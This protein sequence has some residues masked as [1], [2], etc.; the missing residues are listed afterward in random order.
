[1]RLKT[2]LK[3]YYFFSDD[4][5]EDGKVFDADVGLHFLPS[6]WIRLSLLLRNVFKTDV[7]YYISRERV[8]S[9]FASSLPRVVNGNLS[10]SLPLDIRLVGGIE[11]LFPEPLNSAFDIAIR[12]R[13]SYRFSIEKELHTL[14]SLKTIYFREAVPF[15]R[16]AQTFSHYYIGGSSNWRSFRLGILAGIN[17][18]DSKNALQRSNVRYSETNVIRFSVL[19]EYH[20]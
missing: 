11:N 4:I 2:T 1:M 3:F 15:F 7:D 18:V 9:F 14:L 5:I 10:L 17:D 16:T 20:L 19:L 6:G 8:S 13:R 12:T